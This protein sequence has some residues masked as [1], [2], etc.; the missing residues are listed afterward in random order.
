MTTNTE[1]SETMIGHADLIGTEL[2]KE[3]LNE[4]NDRMLRAHSPFFIRTAAV[5]IMGSCNEDANLFVNMIASGH[6]YS[7][8]EMN[9]PLKGSMARDRINKRLHDAMTGKTSAPF[10]AMQTY[11]QKIADCCT[12]GK[13]VEFPEKWNWRPCRP[14][15]PRSN[16][17]K[18]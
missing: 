8:F 14:N 18:L 11:F 13:P 7:P 16:V 6:E 2:S 1:I 10:D 15:D 12:F 9:L 3:Q 17:A 4:L 5:S